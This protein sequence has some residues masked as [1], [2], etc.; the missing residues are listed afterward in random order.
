VVN[1]GTNKIGF[2]NAAGAY[3]F[4]TANNSL[5]SVTTLVDDQQVA[6]H[7]TNG[8]FYV[9]SGATNKLTFIN[10]FNGKFKMANQQ[11]ASQ[12]SAG[13]GAIV[14]GV[15]L[16]ETLSRIFIADSLNQKLVILN[17]LTGGFITGNSSSSTYNI[18]GTSIRYVAYDE[19]TRRVIAT[20][21]TDGTVMIFN[22][23]S[24]AEITASPSPLT[25]YGGG[26][27]S[28]SAIGK[29]EVNS[30]AS[31]AYVLCG[32]K[33]VLIS[34]GGTP[35][36]FGGTLVG[37][38]K[39]TGLTTATALL[40][41]PTTTLLYAVGGRLAM[42]AAVRDRVTSTSPSPCGALNAT[43]ATM[44]TPATRQGRP[45]AWPNGRPNKS[46]NIKPHGR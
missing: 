20:N 18:S 36:Y 15:A 45:I 4:G 31:G 22:A 17:A 34:L 13:S 30:T 16:S 7:S 33:I 26:C 5:L 37:A 41:V 10:G 25:L 19:T 38:T 32:N 2:Y 29:V 11:A 14:T 24:G 42:C 28:P 12:F 3:G 46:G 27:A 39:S 44:T 6:Q 21:P 9:G 35:S 40:Y 8:I 23:T 43:P 1:S